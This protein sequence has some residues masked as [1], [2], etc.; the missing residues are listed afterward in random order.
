MAVVNIVK[1]NFIENVIVALIIL[2]AVF[3]IFKLIEKIFG[4]S[5]ET[6]DLIIALLILNMG[7]SFVTSYTL[8]THLGEHK[9]YRKAMQNKK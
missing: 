5:W 8:W 3:V 4:G 9:G 7:W 6:E 2:F 1:R